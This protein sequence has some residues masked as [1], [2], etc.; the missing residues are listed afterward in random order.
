MK[1]EQ[2]GGPGLKPDVLR[3]IEKLEHIQ[4]QIQKLC[5]WAGPTGGELGMEAADLSACRCPR[6]QSGTSD[7]PQKAVGKGSSQESPEERSSRSLFCSNYCNSTIGK[8]LFPINFKISQKWNLKSNLMCVASDGAT[9]VHNKEGQ[10]SFQTA[11]DIE[12]RHSDFLS[13]L[14]LR[15]VLKHQLFLSCPWSNKLHRCKT[16]L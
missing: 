6:A 4:K 1:K 10:D 15:P 11:Q 3:S 12:L 5:K 7:T 9:S 16:T 2:G 8:N 14:K 13:L